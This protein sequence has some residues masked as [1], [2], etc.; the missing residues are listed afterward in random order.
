MRALRLQAGVFEKNLFGTGRNGRIEG[1]V[2]TK[3]EILTL[4]YTD[5][6]LLQTDIAMNVPLYYERREEP[7]YTSE[8]TSLA[9]LF[10]QESSARV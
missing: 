3:G 6:W 1:L 5:P 7:S 4:S 8:E 9:I 10:Y 2:S